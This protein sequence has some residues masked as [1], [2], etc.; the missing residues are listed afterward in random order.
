MRLGGPQ[1][2]TGWSVGL[3]EQRFLVFYNFSLG[4]AVMVENCKLTQ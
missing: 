1:M 4:L 2:W 3:L